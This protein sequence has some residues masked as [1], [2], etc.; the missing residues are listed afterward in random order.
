LD[1]FGACE[2]R[3]KAEEDKDKPGVLLDAILGNLDALDF[4]HTQLKQDDYQTVIKKILS[5][6][7]ELKKLI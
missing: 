1:I 3:L 2:T 5:Y 4:S 7:D 6:T